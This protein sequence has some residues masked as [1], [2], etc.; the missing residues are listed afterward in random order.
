MR[1]TQGG[2]LRN[3]I[4]SLIGKTPL[5][6][7]DF[8]IPNAK[9]LI[10]L[11]THNLTGSIKDRMAL[12]M[13]ERAEALG[14]VKRGT[15]IIEA[16][17]GNTGI[18]FAALARVFGCKMIA[19]IP[20][21]QSIERVK[22]MKAFG[23][24]VIETPKKEGPAGSVRVRDELAQKIKN[25]WV[26]NQFDN[27][28]N[29]EEHE[30]GTAKELME[31]IHCDLDYFI[32]GVGTGG[33]LIGVGKSLKKKFPKLKVIALEPSES[34]V[35]SGK[36]GGHHNIQGI[37]EGFIPGIVDHK[38]IDGIVTVSTNEAVLETKKIAYK[39]GLLVGFSSGANIAAVRKIAEKHKTAKTF[40]T[41]FAD[42]GERYLSV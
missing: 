11:E 20:Q 28:H 1:K 29:V 31:Q 40:L 32:H 10:K 26:P 9:T 24:R 34:A 6:E 7:I 37:G 33:T 14:L 25:S 13:L 3:T 39:T 22:M 27:P 38:H 21:G 42:R 18:A 15:T 12:Y 8:E 4:T 19:V 36:K 41:V 23:A 17:T 2:N 16:T 5:L 35:L 30:D